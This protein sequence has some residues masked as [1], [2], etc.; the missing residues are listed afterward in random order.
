MKIDYN[1]LNNLIKVN[2]GMKLEFRSNS[3]ILD[4]YIGYKVVLTLELNSNLIEDNCEIIYSS[5]TKLSD[6]TLY[7][8]KIYIK[9]F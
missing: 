4:V 6:V 2:K 8:P 7:I 5:I 9:E 1:T 3:N